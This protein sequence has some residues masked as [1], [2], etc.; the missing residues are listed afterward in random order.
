[1]FKTGLSKVSNGSVGWVE[2]E[3]EV[4][5]SCD[6]VV[7]EPCGALLV[8]LGGCWVEGSKCMNSKRRWGYRLL[9]KFLP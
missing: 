5:P 4:L 9:C 3:V 6:F 7:A 8:F 1:M 2:V